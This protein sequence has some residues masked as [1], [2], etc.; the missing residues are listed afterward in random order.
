MK[1]S[2][3]EVRPMPNDFTEEQE[4]KITIEPA[5]LQSYFKQSESVATAVAS[6]EVVGAPLVGP[7]T[8]KI[9]KIEI[10]DHQES[11]INCNLKRK[12]NSLTDR[13]LCETYLQ[14]IKVN[15]HFFVIERYRM[16]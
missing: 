11:A 3:I 16:V 4:S 13:E 9:D 8:P 1:Q 7:A 15:S 12:R 6:A 5:I 2:E 10:T 14:Y